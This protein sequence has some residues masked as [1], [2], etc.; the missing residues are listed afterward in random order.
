MPT[1]S[2]SRRSRRKTPTPPAATDA[3]GASDDAADRFTWCAMV[4]GDGRIL[5]IIGSLG[6]RQIVEVE[7][8]SA[9]GRRLLNAGRVNLCWEDGRRVDR[10]PASEM[11]DKLLIETRTRKDALPAEP[12]WTR[13]HDR[14]A[15]SIG[16]MKKRLAPGS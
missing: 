1:M 10:I 8:A 15:R 3:Q 6:R 14:M 16:R 11:L 9:E 5:P 4:L 12:L 2:G 13:H 7:P